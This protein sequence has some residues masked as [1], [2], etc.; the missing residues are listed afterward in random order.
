MFLIDP[1]NPNELTKYLRRKEWI[2]DDETIVTLDK[3]GDGN[4]NCVLRADTGK[5]KIIIKQSRGYVE[6]YPQVAAPANRVVI[7]GSFYRK[8]SPQ[9]KISQMMPELL[10]ID[11]ENNI[12]LLEDL[13]DA[14]D[15]TFL[16]DRKE[17]LSDTEIIKLVSY[18]DEL[19][20]QVK[21]L[22]EDTTLSNR[23]MKLLNHEHIFNYPFQANNG[24]NLDTVEDGL[25]AISMP[26]KTDSL[27]KK[28]LEGLGA[29]YL[30]EGAY[31][32]HGDF[33]PGS[34]LKAKAGIKIIDAEFC[35]YGSREF[36]LGVMIAHLYF[37]GLD[38]TVLPL[39]EK[40][41]TAFNEL[42]IEVLDGFT[43]AEIMRRLLGL[44]QLPLKLTLAEREQ[45][46]EKGYQLVMK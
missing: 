3:A 43:G 9:I 5:R 29:L 40:N 10:G 6:K 4:M 44:A 46:V 23:E 17:G 37:S 22:K 26:Y 2:T 41:Y 19:H 45:L 8:I 20:N 39:I 14:K 30:S 36:D 18:L 31:L 34:W 21:K 7:E 42:D 16:Y 11:E 35:F 25:Q 1:G 32:L 12:M 15:Y 24:F 38:E 13:G 28:K 27:L 33:Y